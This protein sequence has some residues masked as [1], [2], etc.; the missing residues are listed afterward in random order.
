[1]N[2]VEWQVDPALCPVH[3]AKGE[4][5]QE[6][7]TQDKEGVHGHKRIQDE[8]VQEWVQELKKESSAD[9]LRVRVYKL[10]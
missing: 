5:G 1:M 4:V 9:F 2:V 7:A 8:A 3:L 10:K 6:A